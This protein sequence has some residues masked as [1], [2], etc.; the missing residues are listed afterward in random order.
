MTLSWL[1]SNVRSIPDH[2]VLTA[3]RS[4]GTWPEDPMAHMI[5][6]FGNERSPE[7]DEMEDIEDE[8]ARIRDQIPIHEQTISRLT[9]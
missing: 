8:N 2:I 4:Q 9:K 1:L 5:D 3:L 7:W 6:F